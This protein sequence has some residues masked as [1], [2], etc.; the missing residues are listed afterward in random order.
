MASAD[1]RKDAWRGELRATLA[2]AWPLILANLT[3]QLGSEVMV[4]VKARMTPQSSD[5]ALVHAINK[6]ERSLKE[7]FSEVRWVFFEPDLAD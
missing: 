5:A 7:R 3:Q 6:V 2:L 1:E 4:A